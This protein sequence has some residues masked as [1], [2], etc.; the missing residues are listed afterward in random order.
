MEKTIVKKVAIMLVLVL[1]VLGVFA[2]YGYEE[3]LAATKP[4]KPTVKLSETDEYGEV[5]IT[6]G[7]TSNADGYR[8][9]YR[10]KNDKSYIKLCELEKSGTKKR[11]YTAKNLESGTY[12]FRVRAYS[13]K[14]GKKVWG[15]YSKVVKIEVVDA[16]TR[17][18]EERMHEIASESYPDLYALVE[19]GKM[20]LTMTND[21]TVYFT[22]GAYDMIDGRGNYDGVKETL[23]WK[24]LD[25]DEDGGKVLL[26]SRYAVD[27]KTY[28]STLEDITWEECT[29]RSW[30]N[31]DFL[32]NAFNSSQ[33]KL[34]IKSEIKNS[35]KN[36]YGISGGNDTKDR[37]FL[38]SYDEAK[39]YDVGKATLYDGTSITA[40]WLRTPGNTTIT[41]SYVDSS[42]R[43]GYKYI[44]WS[45]TVSTKYLDDDAKLYGVVNGRGWIRSGEKGKFQSTIYHKGKY[46]FLDI[47]VDGVCPAIWIDLTQE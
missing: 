45:T 14:T 2:G 23:E 22:F 20:G 28:N 30:L 17:A 31:E 16:A 38:L 11:T 7:K 25:Y 19:N 33:Q 1:T 35:D 46:E 37:V 5:L 9:Y 15:S 42:P 41:A 10:G 43:L 47:K 4:G 3:A 32:Y 13:K 26:I 36:S 12:S 29:L 34:I 44:E 24:V 6:I 39:K 18:H 27:K 8:I 21:S 40:Y